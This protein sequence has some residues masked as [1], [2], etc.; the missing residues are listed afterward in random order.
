M[1]QHV[2]YEDILQGWKY[3]DFKNNTQENTNQ[4]D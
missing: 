2:N 4:N 1:E 3:G